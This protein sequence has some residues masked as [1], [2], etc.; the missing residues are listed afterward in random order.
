MS[1]L[2]GAGQA[3][4]GSDDP[5]LQVSAADA[6]QYSL[7]YDKVAWSD[8]FSVFQMRIA[9]E[10]GSF[11]SAVAASDDPELR[12]LTRLDTSLDFSAPVIQAPVRL[13]DAVSSSGFWDEPV[14]MGGLQIGTIRPAI[15]R[16]VAPSETLLPDALG[17]PLAA[18]PSVGSLPANYIAAASNRF[19]ADV[20]SDARLQTQTL[21]GQG[22]SGYSLEMGRIREDFELRSNNYGSWM[23]SGTYRYGLN[24]DTTLDGQFARIGTEQSVVGLG[25]LEG[26]GSLGQVSARIANSRDTDAGAGWLARF[27]YDFN[28]ENLSLALRTHLQSS[29]Y[30]T[31]N[32]IA[33]AEPLRQRTLASAGWDFGSLGK[34]ALASA[35]QTF[36]DDS[37]RDVVAL[38][39]SMPIM[40]GGFL[41]AAAAYM[42]G[43][44]SN[45]AL[46]LSLR[47][48]FDYWTS[49]TRQLAQDMDN[50][51]DKTIGDAMNVSRGIQPPGLVSSLSSR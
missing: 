25:V 2:L 6:G 3:L 24:A 17:A 9:D 28:C 40:G 11:S 5:A 30:Q 27:G 41:S 42:P 47:F 37:R 23:S 16:V 49:A 29:S 38:S 35:T 19:I 33:A 45:S 34:V 36:A 1:G 50:D 21:A 48:P 51:L 15:P 8:D 13:G 44:N 22:Q 7:S 43:A 32:D 31:V 10:S 14:R 20:D 12:P 46:L 18:A 26:L 4:G 39:H